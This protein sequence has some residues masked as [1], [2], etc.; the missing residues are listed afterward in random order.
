[1][2]SIFND[3]GKKLKIIKDTK[4][5]DL[6]NAIDIGDLN[7]GSDVRNRMGLFTAQHFS[8][9]GLMILYS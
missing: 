8:F 1:M 4:V 3:G 6:A 2:R 7:G 9:L 5:E